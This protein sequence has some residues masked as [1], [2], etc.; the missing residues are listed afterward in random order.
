[1]YE[2]ELLTPKFDIYG[3]AKHAKP[4]IDIE[5][6]GYEIIPGARKFFEDLKIPRELLAHVDEIIQDGGNKIHHQLVPFWDGEDDTFNIESTEDVVLLPNL[7]KVQ[8]LYDEG[9]KM[10]AEFRRIGIEANYI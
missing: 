6:E 2:K 9:E 5:K 1:M 7:S 8:L 4:E 3:F 10:V